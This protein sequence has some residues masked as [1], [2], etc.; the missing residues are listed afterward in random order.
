MVAH[1]RSCPFMFPMRT[2]HG[3]QYCIV[4]HI[5]THFQIGIFQLLVYSRNIV[6]YIIDEY[7]LEIFNLGTCI[8]ICNLLDPFQG[9]QHQ[10]LT[11]QSSI[12]VPF[13]LISFFISIFMLLCCYQ[14]LKFH[15]VSPIVC[16][17]SESAVGVSMTVGAFL[18]QHMPFFFFPN[19]TFYFSPHSYYNLLAIELKLF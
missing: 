16:A 1:A 4:Q 5:V 10:S 15:T 17:L 8:N 9:I 3:V 2:S 13:Y 6:W 11:H 18:I 7:I 12:L 19:Y 14:L